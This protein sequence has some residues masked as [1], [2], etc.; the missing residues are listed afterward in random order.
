MRPN[1][2]ELLE[3]IVAALEAQVQPVV[4]DKWAASTLR[5]ATQL[6][7]FLALRVQQEP[8][9][10]REQAADL[11]AT[12]TAVSP[13]LALPTLTDLRAPLQALLA[14]TPPAPEDLASLD[15]YCD[16]ALSGIEQLVSARDR[17]RTAT[18]STDV[19]EQLIACLTRQ[20]AR[21]RELI[22]PFQSTPPI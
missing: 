15:A 22:S 16:R 11:R 18:G 20:M 1:T 4:Q 21:E 2:A 14:E 12:L 10:L 3:S 6:L 8:Q 9:I 5:S 7:R 17:V 13:L 19:H